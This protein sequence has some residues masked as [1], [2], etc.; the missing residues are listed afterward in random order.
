MFKRIGVQKI[1]SQKLSNMMRRIWE[2][3]W[4]ISLDRAEKNRRSVPRGG[5]SLKNHFHPAGADDA[6]ADILLAVHV[7]DGDGVA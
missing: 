5:A 4:K 6:A 1:E 2:I 3:T 7:H